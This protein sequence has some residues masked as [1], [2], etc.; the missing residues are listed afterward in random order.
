VGL[1]E[2]GARK[3]DVVEDREEPQ[4]P[5]GPE[6][7]EQPPA[8]SESEAQAARAEDEDEAEEKARDSIKKAFE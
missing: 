4:R 5:E 1:G 6:D 8:A 3:E 7:E 2:D